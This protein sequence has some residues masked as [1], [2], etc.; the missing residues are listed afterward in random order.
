MLHVKTHR[1]HD[2]HQHNQTPP[3]THH[4]NHIHQH[5]LLVK[6]PDIPAASP[7][8]WGPLAAAGIAPPP[9]APAVAFTGGGAPY[10]GPSV[11]P[12]GCDGTPIAAATEGGGPPIRRPPGGGTASAAAPTPPDAAA[13]GGAVFLA[14]GVAVGAPAGGVRCQI[15][16]STC[17]GC[18]EAPAATPPAMPDAC[19]CCSPVPGAKG[20]PCGDGGPSGMPGVCVPGANGLPGSMVPCGALA[21]WLCLS[22]ATRWTT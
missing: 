13:A 5:T 6:G 2:V 20:L 14:A 4:R 16:A 3:N 19:C 11:A 7:V 17:R 1:Q 10:A 8:S 21:T 9:A 22:A 15:S 12:G 18:A